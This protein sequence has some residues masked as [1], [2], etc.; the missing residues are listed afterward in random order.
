MNFKAITTKKQA[1]KLEN[2]P[3]AAIDIG[4]AGD[5]NRSTGL[6]LSPP[7]INGDEEIFESGNL[8]HQQSVKTLTEW[9]QG[10]DEAVLIIEAPLSVS[11]T[12]NGN[13]CGRGEFEKRRDKKGK[14]TSTR[15]WYC[16]SGANVTLGVINL[17]R[18]LSIR[19]K[20]EKVT[21]HLLEG[22]VS[23]GEE[24]DHKTVARNLAEAFRLPPNNN[25]HTAPNNDSS[26]SLV[27]Y[28]GIAQLADLPAILTTQ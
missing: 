20:K 14:I 27:S 25:W 2:L 18:N 16:G 1:L 11:F 24:K 19:I 17:C 6:Y 4:F 23:F 5:R 21:L 13:P 7:Q 8:T 9:L 22:F 28:Y 12:D 15:Y 26:H 10:K 3:L